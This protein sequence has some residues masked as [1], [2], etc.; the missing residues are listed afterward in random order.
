MIF[1]IEE[2]SPFPPVEYANEDGLLCFGGT[3]SPDRLRQAY[4]NGIFPWADDPVL[5]F[6]PNPR[7][8]IDLEN[9]SPSKSLL[10]TL[11]KGSFTLTIDLHF[12]KVITACAKTRKSTWISKSFIDS[13]T[14]LHEDGLAHSFEVHSEGKLVGGLYGLSLGSAFFGESMFH[15]KTD[16]SKVAFA[17]LIQFMRY[18][19]LNLLDCQVNNPHL[20]SLGGIDISRKEYMSRLNKALKV[21][22]IDGKWDSK[23]EEYLK[24]V[25]F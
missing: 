10:R 14:Q 2:D 17:H 23:V 4:S 16:A 12:K 3:L 24:Q 25:N 11:K 7:M 6:S 8:I 1:F 15:T 18:H 5:W 21:K 13:Y 19:Q 9:W 20:I 22:T